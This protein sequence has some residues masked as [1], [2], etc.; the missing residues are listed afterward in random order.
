MDTGF[1]KDAV[2]PSGWTLAHAAET[3]TELQDEIAELQDELHS[4]RHRARVKDKL[5]KQ[6]EAQL[7][8]ALSWAACYRSDWAQSEVR[9]WAMEACLHAER[10]E[11][12]P[13]PQSQWPLWKQS[14]ERRREQSVIVLTP[15]PLPSPL[16]N[17]LPSRKPSLLQS[18]SPARKRQRFAPNDDTA[19][20]QT[21][22]GG[23]AGEDIED[24][25]ETQSTP[26]CESQ[27][28]MLWRIISAGAP[29]YHHAW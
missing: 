18:P 25:E 29:S 27:H 19:V 28:N 26:P 21:G 24:A 2:P 11:V 14:P 7:S 1:P 6:L 17:P 4:Y 22:N 12:L 5:I 8:E 15:L 10:L 13:E 3:I 16:L 20:G 9:C 23:T